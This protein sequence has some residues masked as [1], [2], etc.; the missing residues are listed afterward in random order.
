MA[1]ARAA[2][3]ALPLAAAQQAGTQSPSESHPGLSIQTCT[4]DQD[5]TTV[6]KS[7]VLD[8]NW[9]WLDVNAQNCA[10][11]ASP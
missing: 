10:R 1:L 11:P 4:G 3:F 6:Q 8:A 5:C 9:R 2:F 7:I